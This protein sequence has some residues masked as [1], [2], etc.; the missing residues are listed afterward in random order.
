MTGP[1]HIRT[2]I[3]ADISSMAS[4]LP[5]RESVAE[6]TVAGRYVMCIN[7]QVTSVRNCIKTKNLFTA[8]AC[9]ILTPLS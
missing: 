8:A 5:E 6:V 1:K 9:L 7:R 3:L 2:H 4:G